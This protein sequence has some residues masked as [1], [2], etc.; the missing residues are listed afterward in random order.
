MIARILERHGHLAGVAT[1]GVEALEAVRN[2][3]YDVVFMDVQ[4]PEMDGL[5]ATRAIRQLPTPARQP[6]IVALTAAVTEVDREDC[7][8]AGM[9]DFVSKPAQ[10]KDL[11]DALR[12]AALAQPTATQSTVT[13]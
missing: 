8:A 10:A 1:N 4:M 3:V 13:Q 2:G 6:Y 9:N 12:R 11:L 7:V 5:Q